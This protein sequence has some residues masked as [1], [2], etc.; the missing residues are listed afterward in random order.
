MCEKNINVSQTE[1]SFVRKKNFATKK[2]KKIV[3]LKMSSDGGFFKNLIF[4]K[5]VFML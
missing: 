5:I 2:K 3:F 1:K 4:S